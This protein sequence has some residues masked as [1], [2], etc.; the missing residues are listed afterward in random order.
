MADQRARDAKLQQGHDANPPRCAVCVYFRR[1]PH[2]LYI[3]RQTKNRRGKP[4]TIQI[5]QRAHPVRNPLID[6]CSFGNF[7]VKPHHICDEWHGHDGTTLE[8]GND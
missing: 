4:K 6:R 5:R 3:D 2:T 8:P 1:E 7:E